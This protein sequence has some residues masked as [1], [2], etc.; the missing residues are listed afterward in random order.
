[1]TTYTFIYLL[2]TYIYTVYV[3][4]Y[5]FLLNTHTHTHTCTRTHAH[6]HTHTH[7]HTHCLPDTQSLNLISV[8]CSRQYSAQRDQM[9]FLG[10]SGPIPPAS[11]SQPKL[12]YFLYHPPSQ[13]YH[14]VT[15]AKTQ[16][17]SDLF[18]FDPGG[19]DQ[20]VKVLLTLGV[21]LNNTCVEKVAEVVSS[22]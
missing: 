22:L 19:V 17:L 14:L 3:C 13:I 12:V 8:I 2:F 6:T 7:T 20:K 4:I 21:Q 9:F 15:I 10:T 11:A 18:A 16:W 5:T 1:M